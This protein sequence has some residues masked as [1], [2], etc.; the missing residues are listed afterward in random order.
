M[1]RLVKLADKASHKQEIPHV[2]KKRIE[3]I[4]AALVIRV[5]TRID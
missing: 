5:S 3:N 1:L 4:V 2:K